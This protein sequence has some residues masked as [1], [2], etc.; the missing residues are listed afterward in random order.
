MK[1][2]PKIEGVIWDLG[3]VIVRTE[4]LAPRDAL[5]R[6]LG[7]SRAEIEHIV[8]ESDA[9]FSAQL[10]EVDGTAHMQAVSEKFGLSLPEFRQHFFGGDRVDQALVSFVRGLR[11]RRK[12]AL[13]SNALSNL[14]TYLAEEW[15]ISDAF[16]LIVISAEVGMLKPDPAIYQ[17][18]LDRLGVVAAEAV[19]VDDV[20][21]NVEAAVQI[22]IHG[23]V[24]ESSQQAL[25][26]LRSLL[27]RP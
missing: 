27:G 21:A 15:K 5:A 11:L 19:F 20:P 12:T 4:D 1:P 17:L 16:D 9:R 13:L 8:F 18:A 24:F 10:G 25:A 2:A 26:D 22:G 14:R 6:R 3:G 7:L 23:I